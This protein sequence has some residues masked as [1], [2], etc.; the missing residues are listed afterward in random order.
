[1]SRKIE[2]DAASTAASVEA[3]AGVAKTAA[4]ATGKTAATAKRAKAAGAQVYCGPTVRGVAKQYTVYA[5][6]LPAELRNFIQA[7]PE[8]GALLV[9]VE[10]FAQTRK[11]LETAG[12]TEAILYRKIK[13][14]S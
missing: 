8:A 1:M 3:A 2:Q 12:T 7:H 14:I 5:G 10:R 9:P 11:K 6:S 4:E 13:S